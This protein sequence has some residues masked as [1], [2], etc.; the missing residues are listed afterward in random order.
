[1]ITLIYPVESVVQLS[2]NVGDPGAATRED[3]LFVP[4]PTSSHG[5]QGSM[6]YDGVYEVDTEDNNVCSKNF[7]A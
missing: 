1:M 4:V 5:L 7:T 3:A 2:N 6:F